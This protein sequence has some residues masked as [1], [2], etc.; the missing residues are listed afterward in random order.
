M[1]G[2]CCEPTLTVESSDPVT[3]LR[4]V[5]AKLIPRTASLWAPSCCTPA[6]AS[7]RSL[8]ERIS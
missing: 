7:F 4:S 6:G 5:G 1:P 3:N 8:H 2:K